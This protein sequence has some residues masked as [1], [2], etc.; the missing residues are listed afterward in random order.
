MQWLEAASYLVTVVGLPLA[1]FVFLYEQRKQ[2]ENEEEGLYQSLS[3]EYKDFLRL[4]LEHADLRL[5][6]RHDA[7]LELTPEQQERKRVLF[8][9]LISLFERAYIVLYEE[10]PS[11]HSARM[12]SSWEDYIREWCRR[13]DFR[14]DLGSLLEGEDDA[15]G[16]YMRRVAADCSGV[17]AQ[18]ARS[19]T[20]RNSA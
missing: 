13:E 3:D 20:V 2:R 7:S 9:I 14:N 5:T 19:S 4:T 12:W 6:G 1:I 17:Q 15:F 16:S 10:H 11:V 8:A 18:V